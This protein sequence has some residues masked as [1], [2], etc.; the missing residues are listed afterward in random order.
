MSKQKEIPWWRTEFNDDDIIS[1][2]RAI[3]NEK[4]SQG[5]VTQTFETQL[6]EMLDGPF[7]VA[8]TSG[9]VALLMAL[10]AIGIKQ[11]DEV[12]LPNRTWIAAVH[13][14]LI[15]GGNPIII[16]VNEKTPTMNTAKIETAITLKTKAIIPTQL[17]GRAVK[18]DLV[19]ELAKKYKI[20]VIEDSAQGLFS[21][22]QGKYMGTQSDF[23]CF[24]ELTN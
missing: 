3:K 7:V 23:G 21:M 2:T 6:Q 1:V 13:A 24:E 4:I 12:I 5:S 17:S 14:V 10:M 18:M 19:W 22:Y 15:L 9:S 16:D 20:K 11:G 8:T